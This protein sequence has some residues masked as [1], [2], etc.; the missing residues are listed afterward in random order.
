MLLALQGEFGFLNS[1]QDLVTDIQ[2]WAKEWSLGLES[3]S[4]V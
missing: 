4:L 1:E 2:G 3:V